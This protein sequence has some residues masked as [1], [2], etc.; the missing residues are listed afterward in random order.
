MLALIGAINGVAPVAAPIIGG[1]LCDRIG[2]QGIFC[3][4]LAIGALLLTGSYR[5]R[6]SLPAARRNNLS[7]A[8]CC[9]TS[10][11]Y[12]ATDSMR[13]ICCSSP[14]RRAYCSP[15]S[16]RRPLSYRSTSDSRPSNSASASPSTPG[17]IGCAAAFAVRFRRPEQGTRTGCLGMIGFAVAEAAAMATGCSFWIYE[18]LLIGLL[19][20]MGL[21]F[22]TST[23]LA[24]ECTRNESGIASALLGA[25]GFAF[26]GIVSPLVG[27]GNT[28]YPR[29]PFSSS[30]PRIVAGTATSGHRTGLAAA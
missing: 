10:A 13:P 1:T 2:W 27:L 17:A 24:M 22:T 20:S 18:G 4:L 3:I 14:S 6:E 11:P 12:C 15:T 29:V 25:A 5:F 21:T 30:A 26:G 28:M 16:P 23:T 9:T 8:I 7:W 19:F